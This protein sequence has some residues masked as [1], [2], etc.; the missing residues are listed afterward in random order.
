MGEPHTMF[1]SDVEVVSVWEEADDG[2]SS[3]S[4]SDDE[5]T[6][7]PLPAAATVRRTG[8]KQNCQREAQ[9]EAQVE[10]QAEAQPEVQPKAHTKKLLLQISLSLHHPCEKRKCQRETRPKA[11]PNK[12]PF[13]TSSECACR[14]SDFHWP[15]LS[16]TAPAPYRASPK[17][18]QL[19]TSNNEVDFYFFKKKYFDFIQFNSILP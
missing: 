2:D 3:W 9:A 16:R 4:S 5:A 7:L 6:G 17:P 12:P 19:H 13:G 11:R 10:A 1:G 14:T 8:K 18:T 15:R